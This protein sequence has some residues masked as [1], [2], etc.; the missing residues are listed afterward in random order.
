[1]FAGPGGGRKEGEAT[2]YDEFGGDVV[3]RLG[4]VS[5]KVMARIDKVHVGEGLSTGWRQGEVA[6]R[7]LV[8]GRWRE[9]TRTF[10]IER[11]G[12]KETKR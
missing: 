8:D 6:T 10:R 12:R 11:E 2:A 7:L 1:M 9:G 4:G 5:W 3:R